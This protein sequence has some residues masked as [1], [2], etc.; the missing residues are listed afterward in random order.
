MHC[1]EISIQGADG[2]LMQT[3]EYIVNLPVDPLRMQF[4]LNIDACCLTADQDANEIEAD[5][6]VI[7]Q[8]S[9]SVREE[10]LIEFMWL[11]SYKYL[12]GV[13]DRIYL[14]APRR[15][16][17]RK[18]SNHSPEWFQSEIYELQHV[19]RLERRV[20]AKQCSAPSF[21][22]LP[23]SPGSVGP[24][25]L[26]LPSVQAVRQLH[27]RSFDNVTFE[28]M[29]SDASLFQLFYH[30]QVDA[31]VHGV[32][33]FLL[34][35]A[36]VRHK[37]SEFVLQSLFSFE[38]KLPLLPPLDFVHKIDGGRFGLADLAS[39]GEALIGEAMRDFDNIPA[40]FIQKIRFCKSAAELIR[41][42]FD[43]QDS[44][45]RSFDEMM[46]VL[47]QPCTS[48]PIK[49]AKFMTLQPFSNGDISK[50]LASSENKIV[51]HRLEPEFA[52]D[53]LPDFVSGPFSRAKA[54]EACSKS[55]RR[56][57]FKEELE[58]F[59]E[60][61]KLSFPDAIGYAQTVDNLVTGYP[62]AYEHK[63]YGGPGFVE[64]DPTSNTGVYC[65]ENN[66]WTVKDVNPLAAEVKC[67]KNGGQVCSYAELDDYRRKGFSHKNYGWILPVNEQKYMA[68]PRAFST[69]EGSAPKFPATFVSMREDDTVKGDAFCCRKKVD[70]EK[71]RSFPDAVK[72]CNALGHRICY[73]SEL[74]DYS[75]FGYALPGQSWTLTSDFDGARLSVDSEGEVE[76]I[77]P[78]SLKTKMF[79]V[80]CDQ[81]LS[82]K[83]SNFSDH[84]ISQPESFVATDLLAVALPADDRDQV[85]YEITDGQTPEGPFVFDHISK[86][87]FFKPKVQDMLTFNVAFEVK[88][89]WHSAKHAKIRIVP[90]PVL[91]AEYRVLNSTVAQYPNATSKFYWKIQSFDGPSGKPINH[92]AD[93]K[94]YRYVIS[95][96]HIV[97]DMESEDSPI[98]YF[99]TKDPETGKLNNRKDI[100]SV[101]IMAD[102]VVVKS[103]VVL[104]HAHLKIQ[105][106]KLQFQ[107]DGH[108]NTVPV[109]YELIEND[110]KDGLDSADVEVYIS[111]PI[112]YDEHMEARFICSAGNGS[113][114]K[115]SFPGT[116]Q[117]YDNTNW[118][119]EVM[120]YNRG[121][122]GRVSYAP[123][124][125]NYDGRHHSNVYYQIAAQ[126]QDSSSL[127]F[128]P[129]SPNNGRL[130]DRNLPPKPGKTIVGGRP[131]NGGCGPKLVINM[132]NPLNLFT[133]KGGEP[134]PVTE[135][136]SNLLSY[137]SSSTLRGNCL[138]SEIGIMRHQGRHGD[139]IEHSKTH[140]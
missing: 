59:A 73:A 86:I 30:G 25:Y 102:V 57:C 96:K 77:L 32:R 4:P 45:M 17:S 107:N 68:L 63:R 87:F 52:P 93:Q 135:T 120:T 23:E 138:S 126:W 91:P 124:N 44:E 5:C 139:C 51:E 72:Y 1:F 110:G 36:N 94:L 21:G 81:K 35:L 7:T 84:T 100:Y 37:S 31:L 134:G 3:H 79:T 67:Q 6:E 66:V 136:V 69:L 109:T 115:K 61:R 89:R 40:M 116:A 58:Y 11:V 132:I 106:R 112:E 16:L 111:Q 20:E 125:L 76:W 108:F 140:V 128:F 98:H 8:I 71:K 83:Y 130:N 10:K 117:V 103:P 42:P 48:I 101:S 50:K 99:F 14:R 54:P 74:Q 104:P 127:W 95:G 122:H 121:D 43:I 34:A 56:I 88:A 18:I 55:G 27:L 82:L 29:G 114:G 129:E 53:K 26:Q 9:K 118:D 75:R 92:V 90:R 119:D 137:H 60:E 85:T 2:S 19:E 13:C 28:N 97:F 49:C 33:S 38:R 64:R 41:S 47:Y 12:P 80:C 123:S 70:V 15:G 39:V 131:G 78:S 24:K 65:C 22:R 105:S 46:C 113:A 133:V 62:M